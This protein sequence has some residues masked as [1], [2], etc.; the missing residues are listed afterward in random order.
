MY[1]SKDCLTCENPTKNHT[2]PLKRKK[3]LGRFFKPLF[4]G[5]G[6][7]FVCP[8]RKSTD[9]RPPLRLARSAGPA[10]LPVPIT[11]HITCLLSLSLAA[12]Q[13]WGVP[14][15]SQNH[16]PPQFGPF[17]YTS[18]KVVVFNNATSSMAYSIRYAG[19][20]VN[21]ALSFN[22]TNRRHY[23]SPVFQIGQTTD[24]NIRLK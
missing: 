18:Y 4:R 19:P 16:S 11:S 24:L 15:T 17:G 22:A 8:P 2:A 7:H 23:R 21:L 20:V 6:G 14:S 10:S 1:S 9:T 3:R 12:L 13:P 5:S